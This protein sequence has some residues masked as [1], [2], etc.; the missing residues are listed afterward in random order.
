[1]R[2]LLSTRRW[3][4]A[5]TAAGL[6]LPPLAATAQQ[7]PLV[8][9]RVYRST[10]DLRDRI[11]DENDRPHYKERWT[12][13][14]FE[15]HSNQMS[16]VANTNADDARRAMSEATQ[17][18]QEAG[19]L[20]N[21]FTKV[22]RNPNFGIGA[23][24]IVVDGEPQRDRDRPLTTLNVVGQK[25]NLVVHVNKGQPSLDQQMQRV[26]ESAVLA[27]FRTAELDLQFPN[28]VSQGLAG[29][30]AQKG[31]TAEAVAEARP[32]PTTANIG[33]QQWRG[34]RLKQDVLKPAEDQ[35]QEAIA[36]VRF[37]LEGNDSQHTP[38]F[39]AVLRA[40]A[41]NMEQKRAGENLV[42]NRRGEIQPPIATA[43]GDQFF[44]S[45]SDEYA[46]WQK[47]PLVG[48][49]VYAPAKNAAPE[50]EQLQR[51]MVLVL[52]LQRRTMPTMKSNFRTKVVAFQQEPK[53]V[54]GQK[55]AISVADPR[56]VY[57]ELSDRSEGPWA[58][59]DADGSLL[60]SS[61]TERLEEL[62]GDNGQRFQRVRKDDSWRLA[63]RLPDGRLMTAWLEENKATPSRPQVKFD[64]ADVTQPGAEL[65][66]PM[67]LPLGTP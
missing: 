42:K 37:L 1:M 23:L 20:A 63:T 65:G 3:L 57:R 61:N 35:H 38:A 50:L 59:R 14:G 9:N 24:Q 56:D 60:L 7:P 17:A 54:G 5:L 45:L 62:F 49:P 40:S 19:A 36:R 66:S 51:E 47:D 43:Q 64:F 2:H 12:H 34:N 10:A 31:E 67:A 58:T 15:L 52:K 6:L 32:D 44:A 48:Q 33:G 41:Q 30:I 29:Y 55:T 22:H 8:Q 46:A 16:V 28:W 27:F 21:H 18:W 26:R 53:F 39:F 13:R 11:P 25:S 4:K